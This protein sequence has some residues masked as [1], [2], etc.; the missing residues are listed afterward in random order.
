MSPNEILELEVSLLL[1]KYGEKRVLKTLAKVR[2]LSVDELEVNLKRVSQAEKKPSKRKGKDASRVVDEIIKQ[3]PQ[4]SHLLKQLYSRFQSKSFLP[5]LRDIKRFFNKHSLEPR[6]L[7]SRNNSA[8]QVF[9]LLAN[10]DE[11]ELKE[12]IQEQDKTHYSALGIIS[13]EIMKQ[14][15]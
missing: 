10:L 7:S 8:I 3:H 4:K 1:I 5:Q 15:G 11:N 6:N 2:G 12:L 13:D 14:R 9:K